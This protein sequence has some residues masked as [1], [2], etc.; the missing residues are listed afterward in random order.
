MAK[1]KYVAFSSGR[2]GSDEDV[3]KTQIVYLAQNENGIRNSALPLGKHHDGCSV[4]GTITQVKNHSPQFW[5]QVS[6]FIPEYKL[7]RKWL[8]EN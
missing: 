2:T 8:K 4:I 1:G 6:E 7:R 3:T 5:Q